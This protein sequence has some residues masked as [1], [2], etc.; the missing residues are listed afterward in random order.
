MDC[1]RVV[2]LHP[3]CAEFTSVALR[4]VCDKH[5]MH[6]PGCEGDR[7]LLCAPGAVAS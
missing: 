2:H 3:T 6:G 1:S 4:P 5:D 7:E